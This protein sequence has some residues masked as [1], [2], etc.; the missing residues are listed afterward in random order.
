MR[1][2]LWPDFALALTL[3]VA[4]PGSA[5]GADPA[6]LYAEHCAACHGADRLGGLGPALLPENL[7][8]L[9]GPRAAAVIAEGR[10]ATQMPSFA[11]AL[12]KPEID[13]LAAYIASPLAAVPP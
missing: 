3:A 6:G 13:A 11:G 12:A 7:G 1:R 2:S 5:A 9:A 8:R 4:V 10:E